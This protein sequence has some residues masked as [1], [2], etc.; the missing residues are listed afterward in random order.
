MKPEHTLTATAESPWTGHRLTDEDI[1]WA[2][3]LTHQCAGKWRIPHDSELVE[4]MV[5]AAWFALVKAAERYDASWPNAAA[6]RGYAYMTIVGAALAAAF[7]RR[8]RFKIQAT[9]S[10]FDRSPSPSRARRTSRRRATRSAASWRPR[11]RGCAG[12]SRISDAVSRPPP[13]RGA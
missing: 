8:R 13:L 12:P 4:E 1:A 5:A 6:F 2:R 11:P 7:P 10:L 9:A 3:G